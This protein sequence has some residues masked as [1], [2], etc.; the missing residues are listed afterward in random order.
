M[1]K[2]FLCALL[3]LCIATLGVTG[4]GDKA[5]AEGFLLEIDGKGY[6]SPESAIK[7]VKEGQ[8]IKLVTGDF[9]LSSPIVIPENN[10]KSFGFDL[11]GYIL[12]G[13]KGVIVHNGS[14]TLTIK[15]SKNSQDSKLTT[16]SLTNDTV[17]ISGDGSLVLESGTIE[18]TGKGE[19][20][21]SAIGRN[22]TIIIKGGKVRVDSGC[23]I[24]ARFAKEVIITGGEVSS[25][26]GMAIFTATEGKVSVGGTAKI[27]S[28]NPNAEEGTIVLSSVTLSGTN[29]SLEIIGG[30]VENTAPKGNAIINK[31]SGKVEISGGVIDASGENGTGVYAYRLSETIFMKKGT[32]V[33]KG[34]GRA[35]NGAPSMSDEVQ[36]SVS[37]EYARDTWPDTSLT[38]RFSNNLNK[39]MPFSG[40]KYTRFKPTTAVAK[41]ETEFYNSLQVAFDNAKSGSTIYLVSDADMLSETVK[42]QKGNS[43]TLDLNGKRLGNRLGNSVI[44]NVWGDLT[45]IDSSPDKSGLIIDQIENGL[46]TLT[47]SDVTISITETKNPA[48]S[49]PS[50]GGEIVITGGTINVVKQGANAIQNLSNYP[51]RISGNTV[52]SSY[53]G[54]AIVSKKGI[55]IEGP[56]PIIKG[57]Y[58]ISTDSAPIFDSNYVNVKVSMYSLGDPIIPYQQSSSNSY[59]YFEF[60][61]VH[62]IW[63]SGNGIKSDAP[64]KTETITSGNDYTALVKLEEVND[65]FGTA[66]VVG[67][68]GLSLQSGKKTTGFCIHVNFEMSADNG[69][70]GFTMVYKKPDNTYEF[71]YATAD[72]NGRVSFGPVKELSTVMLV[73][74]LLPEEPVDPDDMDTQAGGVFEMYLW[75]IN[76]RWFIGAGVVLIVCALVAAVTLLGKRKKRAIE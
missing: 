13:A 33:I 19:P 24:Y 7:D 31:G 5:V 29:V 52:V 23:A 20:L 37:T 25:Q 61:S 71:L 62:P 12:K 39:D 2:R 44:I 22:G 48:I 30:T 38:L 18:H 11:N 1:K 65:V 45:I 68:Y 8:T 4:F 6:S 47:V 57:L 32:S 69:E 73:K 67:V 56:G 40:Y 35:M 15:D 70:K 49:S 41:I 54:T 3:V 28:A 55:V 60:V 51:V 26:S 34:R 46:G 16:S 64:L 43:V 10:S 21:V 63:I 36:V 9:L 50:R 17:S 58:G 42:N 75:G 72:A 74:G 53:L 76:V 66:D 59:N 27:A 14:G